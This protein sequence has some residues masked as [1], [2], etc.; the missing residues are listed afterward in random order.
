MGTEIQGGLTERLNDI[1]QNFYK[2]MFLKFFIILFGNIIDG[3]FSVLCANFYELKFVLIKNTFLLF[4]NFP[5]HSWF[6]VLVATL[7][8]NFSI[9]PC[10]ALFGQLSRI[11]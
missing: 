4:M 8:Y 10:L 5:Y 3:F 7:Y 1:R 2:H 6:S 9:A 11:V